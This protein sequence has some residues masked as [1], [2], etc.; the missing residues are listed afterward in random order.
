MTQAAVD[1]DVAKLRS[2]MH[3]MCQQTVDMLKLTWEGFKTHDRALLQQAAELGPQIH[4]QEKTLTTFAV[5]QWNKQTGLSGVLQE[6][7]LTPVHLERQRL[8]QQ[9][10]Q[11][12][13]TRQ[14]AAG[15]P[16]PG[17]VGNLAL[18]PVHLE[19]IGDNLELMVRALTTV[20]R[21]GIP[22]T[23]RAIR[24]LNSLFAKALELLEC[25]R[26][27]MLTQ[28]RILLSHMQTEGQRYRA[29]ANEYALAHQQRL[30]EGLCLPR[31]SSIFVALLD[32]FKGIEEH[33]GQIAA[34]LSH[35]VASGAA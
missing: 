13:T 33:L 7:L 2:D 4:L 6:L 21:E 3:H 29:L 19:R 18:V 15:Q 32:Y 11:H 5:Q 23:E 12:E 26:D 1:E 27:V 22:L 34:K 9:L 28:N 30:I 25:V 17:P 20:V 14:G 31:A 8:G 24:E 10:Q 16:T 35:E